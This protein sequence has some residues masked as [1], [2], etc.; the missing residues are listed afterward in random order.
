MHAGLG[1]LNGI[2][3]I[4]HRRG[5]AGEIVDLV[6]LDIERHRHVMAHQLKVRPS[7]KMRDI[8]LGAGKEVIEAKDIVAAFHQ[9]VAEMRAEK[10]GATGNED[11]GAVGVVFHSK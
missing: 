11:A 3:L 4:V 7:E 9:S 8:V 5:R 2:M 10:A 6:H 1:G